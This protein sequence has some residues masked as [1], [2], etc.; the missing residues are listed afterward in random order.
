M[1]Q[2]LDKMDVHSDNERKKKVALLQTIPGAGHHVYADRPES[3][4]KIMN[5]Y[6]D[7]MDVHS[8]N[9][10]KKKVALLQVKSEADLEEYPFTQV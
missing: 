3:F 10:R 6:L 1:N 8:D 4:N 2:Y 5:Q 7:K 9:E